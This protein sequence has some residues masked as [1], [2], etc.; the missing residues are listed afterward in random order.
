MADENASR[1]AS[2]HTGYLEFFRDQVRIVLHGTRQQ[3]KQSYPIQQPL[4]HL[5]L[6]HHK[7]THQA[8]HS[9]LRL[10]HHRGIDERITMC[11]WTLCA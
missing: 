3:S 2:M 8:L 7:S 4:C 1:Q 11:R 6:I 10:T 5:S 9:T